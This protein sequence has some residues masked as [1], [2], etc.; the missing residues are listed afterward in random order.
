MTTPPSYIALCVGNTRTRVGHFQ[1][2]QLIASYSVASLET[3]AVVE[4]VAALAEGISSPMVFMASVRPQA[5]DAIEAA[6][7]KHPGV[8]A[9]ERIGRDIPI[10]LEHTLD[11]GSTLGQDRALNAIAAFEQARQACVVVD[12]GTAVTVDFVDGKGV[13]HGGVIFPGLNMM[14]RALHEQTAALP[15]VPFAAPDAE[16]GALG[17]DT[18]HAMTLG[19]LAAVRG[20][21]RQQAEAAAEFF[22]AYPSIVATGGD[23]AILEDDGLVEHFAA[24]LQLLGLAACVRRVSD[25]AED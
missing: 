5:A 12:V 9:V 6:L 2:G 16:R 14:L 13:F 23:M 20:G 15:A 3:D 25:D 10:P 19:V 21:V 7:E 1:D 8:G 22:G 24:D 18:V 17:R 11:D 4:Q